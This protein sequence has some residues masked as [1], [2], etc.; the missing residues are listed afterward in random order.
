MMH[1]M[2]LLSPVA[3]T[4]RPWPPTS[5]LSDIV[6]DLLRP[7]RLKELFA[8]LSFLSEPRGDRAAAT[9]PSFPLMYNC[10]FL[11][12]FFLSHVPTHTDC[13]IIVKNCRFL[14]LIVAGFLCSQNS[15]KHVLEHVIS[16]EIKNTIEKSIKKVIAIFFW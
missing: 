1:N 10:L 13:S 6:I 2:L 4:C 7:R 8:S 14:M 5:G 3:W 15:Q 11:L 12:S 9:A 16:E